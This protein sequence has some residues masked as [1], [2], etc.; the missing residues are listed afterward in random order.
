MEF[1]KGGNL[2]QLIKRYRGQRIPESTIVRIFLQ[3]CL[4]VKSLHD[5]H[6]MHRCGA[7]LLAVERNR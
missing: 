7:S 6:I 4:A 2:K 1:A 5:Q 3:L